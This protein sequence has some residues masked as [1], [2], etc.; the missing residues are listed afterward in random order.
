MLV[1]HLLIGV[2]AH[3]HGVELTLGLSIIAAL[4]WAAYMVHRWR[5]HV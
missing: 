2:H 3:P 1:R 4:C 5:K